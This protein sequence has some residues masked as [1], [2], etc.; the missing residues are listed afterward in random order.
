MRSAHVFL[1]ALALTASSVAPAA[2]RTAR[3]D[4][5][6]PVDYA[7]GPTACRAFDEKNERELAEWVKQ[8]PPKPYAY[9]RE[10]TVLGAPWG[11]FLKSIGDNADLVLATI[12]PHIG[13]QLRA[14]TPAAMISWPWSVPIGPAYT[15]SRKKGTFVVRGHEAHRVMLEPGIVS[16]NRGVGVFVRPGYRFIYQPSDWVVGPGAGLGSTIELTG[17]REPTRFSVG[18]EAV[19]RFGHCCDPGYFTLAF[20]Y[21]HFFKGEVVD[22][23]SG[24]LG[25]VFF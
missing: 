12:L 13:A 3:A 1:F 10:D 7:D 24:S 4:E 17:N 2:V 20:R 22:I 9:P 19:L 18:P 5:P 23:L 11:A 8:Q 15:C 21:D 25:Y 16:S 6:P 14:D